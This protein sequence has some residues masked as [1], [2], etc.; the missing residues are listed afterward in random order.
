MSN[1]PMEVVE[2]LGQTIAKVVPV[3]I[4]LALIFSVLTHFWACNP[5]AQW[6]RKRELVTDICYWFL[7]PV[8]GRILRIGLLIGGF[9]GFLPG[10]E[11]ATVEQG[12][13][14]GRAG[15]P[16]AAIVLEH[17]FRMQRGEHE[18]RARHS[19][20]MAE[21]DRATVRIYM[22]GV[23]GKELVS[24]F[25]PFLGL[26]QKQLDDLVQRQRDELARM[27]QTVVVATGLAL[28]LALGIG[29]LVVSRIDSAA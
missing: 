28:A 8:F 14:E 16:S 1:L 5:G 3:T 4:A 21:S 2:M 19:E 22:G 10:L 24:A 18:P 7:V 11:R 23:I 13:G 9:G 27:V 20:R 12:G 26:Q 15:A 6:W 29:S 25:D 17:V